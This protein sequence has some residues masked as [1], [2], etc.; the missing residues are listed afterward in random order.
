MEMKSFRAATLRDALQQVQE[1]LGP[2]AAVLQTREVWDGWFRGLLGKRRIEVFASTGVLSDHPTTGLHETSVPKFEPQPEPFAG[3][4][5]DLAD[6]KAT[7]LVVEAVFPN[8]GS[9]QDQALELAGDHGERRSTSPACFQ[10]FTELLEAD[11]CEQQAREMVEHA[12]QGCGDMANIE[13]LRD[14]V[15]RCISD[16]VRVSGP[17]RLTSGQRTVVAIVGPTGV[18]KTTTI[19]KLAANFRLRERK[20]VA[21]VT[22]DTYR[23]AAVEQLRT[24]AD[25]IDLPMHVV[26]TADETRLALESLADYDLVLMDTAGRSPH[27]EIR[28]QE[29]KAIMAAAQPDEVQLVLSTT[30]GS[31]ALQRT[32]EK[33]AGV[34]ITSLL[35][36]KLDESVGLGDLLPLL[37]GTRL[38]ISYVT[39]GQNVPDDI[40]E[41]SV[42]DL[43]GAMLRLPTAA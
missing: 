41:A 32:A 5:L 21:L 26:S 36:T 9:M 6:P 35:L 39:N 17:I 8:I 3:R 40:Q 2:D 33:F 4:E 11:W 14:A 24:Y 29:L 27:D 1:E 23:I 31:R 30:T 43:P 16:A 18:G 15:Y 13:Q 25:I 28:I 38:P 10:L 7:G 42:A 34:G 20:R 22:V 37:R 19:A 12:G